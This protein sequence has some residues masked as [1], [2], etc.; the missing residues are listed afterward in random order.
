MGLLNKLFGTSKSEGKSDSRAD[1]VAAGFVAAFRDRVSIEK[2]N[3]MS[4]DLV[5]LAQMYW[6]R[7]DYDSYKKLLSAAEETS[8]M[9]QGD[10]YPHDLVEELIRN[11][12]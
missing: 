3:S 4:E 9:Y 2:L 10:K 6:N 8:Y 12:H 7:G 5:A 11:S 1:D